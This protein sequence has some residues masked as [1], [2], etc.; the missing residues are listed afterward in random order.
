M[1]PAIL[2]NYRCD[3]EDGVAVETKGNFMVSSTCGLCSLTKNTLVEQTD[4][5]G[6]KVSPDHDRV[7]LELDHSQGPDM[8]HTEQSSNADPTI[9]HMVALAE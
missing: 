5:T 6:M 1:I 2:Q 7:I 4:I 9:G 8:V 3:K